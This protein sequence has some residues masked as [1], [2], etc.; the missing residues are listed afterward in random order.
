MV[1]AQV[2]HF[3]EANFEWTTVATTGLHICS[4]MTTMRANCFAA[5]VKFNMWL[6]KKTKKKNG[7][8]TCFWWTS[9]MGLERKGIVWGLLAVSYGQ[10][11]RQIKNSETHVHLCQRLLWEKSFPNPAR[12]FNAVRITALRLNYGVWFLL[13]LFLSMSWC[14]DEQWK[15]LTIQPVTLDIYA[16]L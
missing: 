5:S 12:S 2:T 7:E 9:G 14:L 15:L 16:P 3:G 11:S 10:Y 1:Y 13:E 4:T 6:Q 8:T